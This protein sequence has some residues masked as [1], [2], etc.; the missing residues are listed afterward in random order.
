MNLI[1]IHAF[2]ERFPVI[3]QTMKKIR[4]DFCDF[5]PNWNKTNSFRYQLMSERFDT[6]FH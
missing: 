1:L 4:V 6:T 5:G 2:V 3:H